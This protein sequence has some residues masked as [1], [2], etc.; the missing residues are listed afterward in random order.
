MALF[1]VTDQSFPAK[2]GYLIHDSVEIP[3]GKTLK[4]DTSPNGEEIVNSTVPSGKVWNVIVHF[5]ITETD[6]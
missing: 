2:T 6:A 5:E 4:M 1:E 3:A